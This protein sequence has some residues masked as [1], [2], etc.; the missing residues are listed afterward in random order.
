MLLTNL[1]DLLATSLEEIADAWLRT[2][3]KR[4]TRHTAP[5]LPASVKEEGT[6]SQDIRPRPKGVWTDPSV[7][8]SH[9]VMKSSNRPTAFQVGLFDRWLELGCP[10]ST[11]YC[12]LGNRVVTT[13]EKSWAAMENRWRKNRHEKTSICITDSVT[14]ISALFLLHGFLPSWFWWHLICT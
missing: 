3:H 6:G 2:D 4:R 10:K 11:L 9:W 13:P 12:G 8:D 1:A 7:T 5:R 14:S